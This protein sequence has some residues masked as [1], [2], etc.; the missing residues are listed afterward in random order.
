[1]NIGCTVQGVEQSLV[2]LFFVLLYS[3]TRMEVA[4]YQQV[5]V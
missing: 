5:L 1:M 4:L 2:L 3:W